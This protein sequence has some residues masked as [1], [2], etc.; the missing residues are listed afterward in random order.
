[1]TCNITVIDNSNTLIAEEC[2]IKI[3]SVAAQ[4]PPGIGVPTGGTTG[5]VLTKSSNASFDT[6]WSTGGSGGGIPQAN[7]STIS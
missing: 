4:G 5:Q 3:V 2:E 1:M 6:Q 7:F